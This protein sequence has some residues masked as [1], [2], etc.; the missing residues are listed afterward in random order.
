MTFEFHGS[1]TELI[2]RI[3]SNAAAENRDIYIDDKDPDR[4]EIGFER[5]GHSGGRFFYAAITEKD[6][7][8]LLTGEAEDS[9]RHRIPR[10][11]QVWNTFCAWAGGL[12]LLAFCAMILWVVADD[13]GISP[14]PFWAF[15]LIAAIYLLIRIPI[16]RSEQK[17]ADADF[18]AFLT[19]ALQS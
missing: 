1:R 2:E 18:Y 12:G 13:L 17:R 10:R 3:E 9:D 11:K 8:L 15:L 16:S 6:G 14:L 5:H 19:R 7:R 4:L